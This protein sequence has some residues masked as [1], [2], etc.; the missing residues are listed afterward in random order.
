MYGLP[1]KTQQVERVVAPQ[2]QNNTA[3]QAWL[4]A[5]A[6]SETAIEAL[7]TLDAGRPADLLRVR[8]QP[9][10]GNLSS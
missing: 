4:S 2:T 10:P 8:M 3:S 6:E 5:E 7:M 1:G 9:I